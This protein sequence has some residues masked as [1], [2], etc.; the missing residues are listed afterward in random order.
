MADKK[1][2]YARYGRWACLAAGIALTA[3]P[4][5]LFFIPNHIA[6]G[7]VTGVATLI[8]ALIGLPV[9]SIAAVLNLPLFLLSLRRM[10]RGFAVMSLG[11]MLSVSALI[12]LLPIGPA[13]DDPMLAAIFGGAM[14]GL[15]V[16]LVIRGGATTGGTDMLAAMVHRRYPVITVGATLLAI[17]CC[18]VA[19]SALVFSLQ[20]ALFAMVAIFITTQ[21]MDRTIEGFGSAKAF[22]IFS[23]KADELSAAVLERLKRGATLLHAKGAYTGDERDVLLC[24]VTRLQIPQLKALVNEI[25]PAA[26]LM[27]TDVREALGEGFTEL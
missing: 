8:N 5:R 23:R 18:V 7:G 4:F 9:G 24:V 17:D 22:F 21:V 14:L 1:S 13:T 27:V 6:P 10:G 16:G 20:S 3:L 12:D 19:A 11:C 26:F 2:V 15:G 25:D